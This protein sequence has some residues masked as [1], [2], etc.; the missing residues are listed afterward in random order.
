MM[1]GINEGLE[2]GWSKWSLASFGMAHIA[3]ALSLG[4]FRDIRYLQFGFQAR[5]T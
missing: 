1:H 3:I 2:F 5:P 4:R